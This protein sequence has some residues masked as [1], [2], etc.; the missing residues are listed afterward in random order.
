LIRNYPTGKREP[1]YIY[2]LGI[3]HWYI[4]VLRRNNFW[5]KF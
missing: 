2:D 5:R 3:E 1:R 4:S